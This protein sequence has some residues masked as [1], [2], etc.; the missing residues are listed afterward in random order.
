MSTHATTF[1]WPD[2]EGETAY[3]SHVVQYPSGDV[4]LVPDHGPGIT[5]HPAD[6]SVHSLDH[7]IAG[8]LTLA[9][10]HRNNADRLDETAQRLT[11]MRLSYYSERPKRRGFI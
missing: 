4:V 8:V 1:T 10:Y 2:R 11:L 6:L 5:V 7:L 9:D 3:I